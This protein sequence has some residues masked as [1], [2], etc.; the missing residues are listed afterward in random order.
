MDRSEP[1]RI[2]LLIPNLESGGAERQAVLLSTGLLK[3]GHQVELACLRGNGALLDYAKANGLTVHDLGLTGV[4]HSVT[5]L[6]RLR[7]LAGAGDATLVYAMQ[8]ISNVMAAG[9]RALGWRGPIVRRDAAVL[10]AAG[11]GEQGKAVP[12]PDEG[13]ITQ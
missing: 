6:W 10:P 7:Q 1:M 3:R 2:V 12:A 8:P 9:L 5:A 4:A 11:D 13:L